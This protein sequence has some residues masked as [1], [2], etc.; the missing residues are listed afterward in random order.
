M[1]TIDGLPFFDTEVSEDVLSNL[2]SESDFMRVAVELLKEI[3]VITSYVISV[4]PTDRLG[5]RREWN[6]NEAILVGLLVRLSK[7]QQ[8]ITDQV[9]QH[10]LEIAHILYRCLV[11]TTVNLLFLLERNS[12]QL[13][14]DYVEYSLGKEKQLLDFIEQNIKE[15]GEEL[16]IE[17]RMRRSILDYAHQSR[18][19]LSGLQ[20]KKSWGGNLF[21]R[22]RALG[23]DAMYLGLFGLP[24][25]NVHGN[26]QDLLTYH[27]KERDGNFRPTGEWHVPR[28][29]LVN[30]ATILSAKA[31]HRYLKELPACGDNDRLRQ[32][33]GAVVDKALA[34]ERAHEGFL[35]SS[36]RDAG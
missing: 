23:M 36:G 34:L 28:P 29:Q 12:D 30:T 31:C 8:A 15:R 11:E 17:G 4:I 26:W 24:S 7:L 27:L 13:F 21:E 6:R 25:H 2:G 19:D 16:P 10:R 3:G 33:I 20:A 14:Q 22:A 32:R 18:V 9:C 35:T 5:R 1:T